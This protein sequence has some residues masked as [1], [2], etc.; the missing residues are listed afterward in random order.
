M[1]MKIPHDRDRSDHPAVTREW[2]Y[3]WRC[4]CRHTWTTTHGAAPQSCPACRAPHDGA[5]EA[6]EMIET[7][8]AGVERTL[9]RKPNR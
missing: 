9:Y 3:H 5:Q 7:D 2:R 1:P 8:A 4:R 6:S